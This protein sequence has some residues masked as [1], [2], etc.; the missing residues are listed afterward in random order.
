MGVA[1]RLHRARQNTLTFRPRKAEGGCRGTMRR[2]LLAIPLCLALVWP[3]GATDVPVEGWR[4][5]LRASAVDVERRAARIVV[6]D[7]AIAP[8]FSDPAPG[9]SLV[10]SGGA[11][12]GQ[13]RAEIQLEAGGWEPIRGDGVLRG[14]VYRSSAP[15]TQGIRKVVVRPGVLSVT[16]RGGGWPCDLSAGSQRP[17]VSVVLRVADTRYCAAFGGTVRRNSQ[18]GFVARAA[19]A[20]T[21]CPESDLT[22]ANLNILHGVFCP[23]GSAACRQADRM[24]LLFQW[25]AASGCPDVVTLQEVWDPAV[26]L[27]DARLAAPCPFV[28]NR[29]Y[30]PQEGIDDEVILSRYPAV[31]TG[32][33]PLFGAIPIR[34][35]LHA[36]LDHPIGPVDVFTTHLSSGSDLASAPCTAPTCPQPCLDAGAAT[37]RQCQA[38][39]LHDYVLATHDV[40]TPAVITGDFNESPGTFVYDRFT[41]VAGW[42]DTY[43][44]AGN[45]ECSPATGVG[46]TS[47]RED[48]AL[49]DLESPASNET[50]RID[51]VFLVPP[52]PGSLCAA[53]LDPASDGDADGTA[54]RIFADLPNP[55]APACGPAPDPVC[56]PS[57]HEGA[58]LDLNCE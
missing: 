35:V 57:D 43:L 54:T 52:G 7:P 41:T 36:R 19:A 20:P 30:V 10:V 45:P 13:C 44:A 47:G 32:Q 26:A 38:V 42:P 55:F 8:P 4:I 3:A 11:G 46:C 50:E 39:Q 48:G 14:Y 31:A 28:Y 29:I 12:P 24:D 23:F 17:P 18:G 58:E 51:Y 9:A 56:W 27:I 37:N 2:H 25:I 6:H 40:P 33:L 21:A 15:G 5:R 49:T 1:P 34:A 22:V 53:T 16:A